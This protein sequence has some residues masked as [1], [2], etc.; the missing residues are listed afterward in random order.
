ME[1]RADWS[2]GGVFIGVFVNTPLNT[3]IS[4]CPLILY[5]PRILE[6]SLTDAHFLSLLNKRDSNL[7]SSQENICV[8]VSI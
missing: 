7:P 5:I 8:G 6:I 2:R 4:R 3:I 1:I